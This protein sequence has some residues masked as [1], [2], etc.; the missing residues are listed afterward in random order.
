MRASRLSRI[1]PTAFLMAAGLLLVAALPGPADRP[2]AE[3]PTAPPSANPPAGE[4][5]IASAQIRDPRFYH[6]VILLVR[7]DAKGAFGIVINKPLGEQ[8]IAAL[9]AAAAATGKG[10]GGTKGGEAKRGGA[11]AGIEGT[12]RVFEGGP[13]Q[14]ELGFIVHSPDYR[15]AETTTV[16]HIVAVTRTIDTLRDI[17]HHKG[18]RKYLFALGYAGWGAGQLEDEMARH[19][20]FTTPADEALI[21]DAD[22]ATLWRKALQLRTREL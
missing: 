22:R 8:P 17:G 9:L 11:D 2:Q 21:F 7:H 14:P 12:I 5:L 6:A 13:V 19:D 15:R 20:W 4:L 1:V 3:L 18:P 10:Q 16:D